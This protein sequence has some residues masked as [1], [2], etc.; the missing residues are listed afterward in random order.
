MIKIRIATISLLILTF[1]NSSL[2]SQVDSILIE[3]S[4]YGYKYYFQGEKVSGNDVLELLVDH[5]GP[6][7]QFKSANE[8]FI[9]ANIFSVF[10]IALI[11]TP[12]VMSIAG[13]DAKWSMA[14]AG[15]G[16]ILVSVPLI[17]KFNKNVPLAI[18]TYNSN[19]IPNKETEFEVGIGAT[20][21]GIGL[22][23]NF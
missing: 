11:A 7:E 14:W 20:S 22:C 21:N 6:Y 13:S 17:Y 1:F 4:F 3:D 23:V 10:G 15:A 5:T 19:P 18:E 8:A 9:F 12:T 2:F 16:L